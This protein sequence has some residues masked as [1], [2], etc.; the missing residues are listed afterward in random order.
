MSVSCPCCDNAVHSTDSLISIKEWP[1]TMRVLATS[2]DNDKAQ[3]G[4]VRAVGRA[5]DILLAFTPQDNELTVGE[6]VKR[7]DLSRPTL[8]RLL[9]TLEQSGFLLSSGEPQRFRLGPAGGG[10]APGWR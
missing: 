1:D 3:D 5:L 2:M 7:V 4:A 10:L 8:Y 9:H 6:L